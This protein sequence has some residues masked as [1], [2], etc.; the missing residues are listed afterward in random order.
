[1]TIRFLTAGESHGQA[2]TA[3]LDGI[4]AGLKLSIAE[5]NADLARRQK[6]LGAGGRMRIEKD[7]VNI[8]SGVL[9][10]K[11]SGG[12]ITLQV[13]NQDHSRWQGKAVAAYTMPRPGHADL[14]GVLKY[15]YNDIRPAL[16]R[17]S[18]RETV[19]RVAVGAVCRQLLQALG[20]QV[21]GYVT[22][23]GAVSANLTDMDLPTR[24]K[25]ATENESGCPDEAA[26]EEMQAAI[27]AAMQARD[28]LGGIIEITALGLPPGL[29]SFVQSDRR[30]DAILG[31]AVLS[32]QAMKGVEIGEAFENAHLP[33]TQAHDAV[34]FEDGKIVRPT[35]RC[36]GLEG[37]ITNGQPLLIR[38]A[39]KP[40]ATTLT[41]QRSVD[42]VSGQESETTYERSDF[43]PVPRAVV[44]LEAVIAIE[45]AKAMLEKLGGDSMEEIMPRLATLHRARLEDIH[46]DGAAH[47]WWQK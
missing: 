10:G 34:L 17:A 31:A 45:L 39:M 23:I 24:L 1:M 41:P 30:L 3:I 40:I 44:I 47:I 19:S 37:G 38:A 32:V 14:T 42:L 33:G 18:A 36:G 9:D 11:T 46:L 21:G 43:C 22:A 2:M 20:V 15:G 8:L 5:I 4:P 29:G 6:T 27:Q 16:E 12:P 7:Q 35:N 26:A 28:T 25:K 13:I